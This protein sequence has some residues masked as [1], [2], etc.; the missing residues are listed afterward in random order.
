MKTKFCLSKYLAG[1]AQRVTLPF[2]K[3]LNTPVFRPAET[4]VNRQSLNR[5]DSEGLISDSRTSSRAWRKFS[6]IEFTWLF[7]VSQLR[8]TGISFDE[9]RILKGQ[10]FGNLLPKHWKR[11]GVKGPGRFLRRGLLNMT[12]TDQ[13]SIEQSGGISL[14]TGLI[15]QALV[16][17]SP[18]ALQVFPALGFVPHFN[19]SQSLLNSK[20]LRLIC[21]NRS[22]SIPITP[23]IRD[24]LF[25]NPP[26]I[27]NQSI[28]PL[29]PAEKQILELVHTPNLQRVQLEYQK[30]NPFR[31]STTQILPPQT[32]LDSIPFQDGQ[33]LKVLRNESGV[34]G[35]ECINHYPLSNQPH[36]KLDTPHN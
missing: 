12:K 22:V 11:I 36:P 4:G 7:V 35:I 20:E 3:A 16:L 25:L 34:A 15:A 2:I 17:G 29:S 19:G 1:E 13:E 5:W 10:L 24:S 23:F 33:E 8:K 6:P 14:F 32:P 28:Q 9:I 21:D 31:A 30:G 27:Q 18:L 26:E